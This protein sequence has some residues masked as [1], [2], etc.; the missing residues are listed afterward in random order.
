MPNILHQYLYA[1]VRLK[2]TLCF[3]C[4]IVNVA[5][6]KKNKKTFVCNRIVTES[7]DKD[8]CLSFSTITSF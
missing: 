8:N 4:G 5:G 3:K 2:F 7:S 1:D 6:E